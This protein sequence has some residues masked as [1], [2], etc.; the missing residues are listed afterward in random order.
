MTANAFN[1]DRQR[2]LDAGMNDFISKPV[3]PELF[4]A[5]LDKWLPPIPQGSAAPRREAP[6]ALAAEPEPPAPGVPIGLPEMPGVDPRLGMVHVRGHWPR[7]LRMLRQFERSYG[8]VYVDLLRQAREQ[9]DWDSGLRLAHTLKG[10]ARLIGASELG[11]RA[12]ALE[13]ELRAGGS[14]RCATLEA[15]LEDELQR[16][17]AGLAVALA[18][19][20]PETPRSGH[21]EGG[22]PPARPLDVREARLLAEYRALLVGNDTVA[23]RRLAD[24]VEVLSAAGV[25]AGPIAAFSDAV[26]GFDFQKAVE[27]LE[28]MTVGLG[29]AKE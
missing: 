20:G 13:G 4:F 11:R 14:A 27:I 26:T 12:E 1:E 21:P 28:G 16:I 18:W 17:M 29:Q 5:V 8:D 6:G 19:V 23:A 2:C 25:T 22:G 10:T 7:Y 3:D 9:G 15:A 24:V